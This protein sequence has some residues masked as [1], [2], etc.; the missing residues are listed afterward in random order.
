MGPA[1]TLALRAI[2]DARV[3]TLSF[4]LLFAGLP[5]VQVIGY[6][7]T[8]PT[9]ADRLKFAQTFGENKAARLF[10]G[11]PYE[12]TTV[13]GYA[14]WR[15]AGLLSLFAAFFGILAAVR[16]FR[17]EEESGRFELVAAGTITRSAA[18]IARVAAIAAMVVVLWAAALLGL[19]AG[20]LPLAGSA[21]LALATVVAAIIY[22]GVGVVACQWLPTSRGAS[23][24]AG[25][26]LA[27]DFTV[28]VMADTA[29]LSALH[30]V[31][32]LGWVEE[33]RPFAD[34]RPAVLLLPAVAIIV[35]LLVAL[36]LERRRDVGTALLATDDVVRRPARLVLRSPSLL[37]LRSQAIS[38]AVWFLGTGA[39]AFIVGTISKSVASGVSSTIEEQLNKLGVQVATAS[40]YIG[41]TFLF[42]ILAVSLFGCS[43]L[44]AIRE[45]EAEGRLETLFALPQSRVRWLGGRLLVAATGA[46]L[47]SLAAGLAAALGATAV[48]A[49]VSFLRLIGAGLNVLPASLLFLGIGTLLVA[50]APRSGVG[51]SYAIVILAFVWE[52]VGGLLNVP[53]WLLGISPFHQVGLVPAASF[54]PIAA[55]V[56]L[57]TGVAAAIAAMVRFRDRDLVGT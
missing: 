23:E 1:R 49:D 21:Y 8:Y 35:L 22:S 42:F 32:P 30:W 51:L 18:F 38:L 24:L 2:A 10:Y 14:T 17:A 28:R 31:T 46:T 7:S 5:L 47:L 43:Q 29:D 27:V 4:G 41:L 36:V 13:G 37:A 39:F 48:G 33:L 19:M 53:S 34:P 26:V 11:T 52:L 54:R 16:A 40:G 45:D 6:R 50:V 20:R 44:A 55:V 15:A 25:G 57:A 9:L 3:R 56:M 12:L